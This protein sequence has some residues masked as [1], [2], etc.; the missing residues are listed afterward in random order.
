MLPFFLKLLLNYSS[1]ILHVRINWIISNLTKLHMVKL[2][3]IM[4]V[5]SYDVI[6]VIYKIDYGLQL[7]SCKLI[8]R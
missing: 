3:E 5:N 2:Y 1:L 8:Y 4:N 6:L 7:F